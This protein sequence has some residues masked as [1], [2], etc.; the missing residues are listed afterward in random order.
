MCQPLAGLKEIRYTISITRRDIL[1]KFFFFLIL[2]IYL[3]LDNRDAAGRSDH[4]KAPD[5]V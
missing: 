3:K 5:V 1:F 4:V 2:K